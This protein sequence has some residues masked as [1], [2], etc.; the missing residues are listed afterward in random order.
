MAI[1]PVD[2]DGWVVPRIYSP[3]FVKDAQNIVCRAPIIKPDTV[4]AR[5]R[6]L[7]GVLLNGIW[8]PVSGT[9]LNPG[10]QFTGFTGTKVQVLTSEELQV[11]LHLQLLAYAHVCSRMLTYARSCRCGSD[12]VGLLE[13][14]ALLAADMLALLSADMRC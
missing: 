5:P 8:D 9:L 2:T 10:A 14:A 1:R 3:A 13:R 6:A 11:N 7:V 4:P 12:F